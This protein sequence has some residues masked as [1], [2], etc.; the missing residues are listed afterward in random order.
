MGWRPSVADKCL[1]LNTQ[2]SEFT[3]VILWVD[4]FLFVHELETTWASFLKELR[5]RFNVPTVGDLSCFLGMS[6]K[7]DAQARQMHISQSTIIG[8][9]L[10]RAQMADCTTPCSPGVVFS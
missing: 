8:N 1:F 7:Y 6:V 4:D 10:E 5:S 3:A 9:L 2:L